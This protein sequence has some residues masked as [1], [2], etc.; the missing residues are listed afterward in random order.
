MRISRRP[1]SNAQSMRQPFEFST[2]SSIINE[3]PYSRSM[4]M[5]YEDS[6]D[7]GETSRYSPTQVNKIH[8]KLK[9][10]FRCIF[11]YI[12]GNETEYRRK[13]NVQS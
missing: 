13:C 11:H 8:F 3:K 7:W 6:M 10:S 1:T 9:F 12:I 2:R 5:D 4:A